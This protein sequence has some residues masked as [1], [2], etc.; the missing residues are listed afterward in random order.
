M[1]SLAER[2]VDLQ[3]IVEFMLNELKGDGENVPKFDQ[4]A[5]Q[6]LGVTTGLGILE[7]LG[8]LL[9]GQQFSLEI[10]K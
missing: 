4:S 10:K 2:I 1:P 5:F 7:S 3:V 9:R 8:M 6:E